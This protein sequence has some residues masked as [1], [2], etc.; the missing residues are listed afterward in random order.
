MGF[1][2]NI[3]PHLDS[4]WCVHA[5]R[6]GLMF[7]CCDQSQL[8]NMGSSWPSFL[9]PIYLCLNADTTKI[10]FLSL[11]HQLTGHETLIQLY[12][13]TV[14]SIPL[15]LGVRVHCRF[16]EMLVSRWVVYHAGFHF[17]L[18]STAASLL[19]IPDDI[20]DGDAFVTRCDILPM[21]YSHQSTI[22]EGKRS[23]WRFFTEQ[24]A[25]KSSD[26]AILL[27]MA[28]CNDESC[29]VHLSMALYREAPNVSWWSSNTW[30][31]WSMRP[32]IAL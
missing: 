23:A 22:G 29:C 10:V 11:I 25:H 14:A 8:I 1:F 21:R 3:E 17:G 18:N 28:C 31:T 6:Q 15:I 5:V 4:Q 16:P 12:I 9:H 27:M 30:F 32:F 2:R 26:H 7:W 13:N 24:A 19:M 20:P